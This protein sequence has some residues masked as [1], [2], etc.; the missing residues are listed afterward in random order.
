MVCENVLQTNTKFPPQKKKKKKK[1]NKQ[2]QNFLS[3]IAQQWLT[4]SIRKTTWQPIK[5]T[6]FT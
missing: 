3:V 1:T 6:L 5:I 2:T 4:G